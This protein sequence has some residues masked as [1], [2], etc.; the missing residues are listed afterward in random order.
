MAVSAQI[1]QKYLRPSMNKGDTFVILSYDWRDLFRTN[2]DAVREKLA[3]D[4]LDTTKNNFFFISWGVDS[5]VTNLD[6]TLGT[7]HLKAR[8]RRLRPLYDFLLRY[9][10]SG[11]LKKHKL[12]PK[13]I[14][15]YDLGMAYA[16]SR[17]AKRY[18][19]PLILVITNLPDTLL[20]TRKH[21][22]IRQY[23]QHFVE[24]HAAPRVSHVW[25]ISSATHQYARSLGI[26]EEAIHRLVPDSITPYLASIQ[27]ITKGTVREKLG[28]PPGRHIL[29]SVGRL[30]PEKGFDR[31]LDA[32]ANIKHDDLT[33]VIVGDGILR[34]GLEEKAKILGIEKH[35]HF[36]GAV[37]HDELWEYYTD[38][39]MFVLLSRS[40][41]L[42][43]VV[44]EAMYTGLPVIGSRAEGIIESIGK[45]NER[46]F[47]W[48][49]AD[50]YSIFRHHIDSIIG[51]E[52]EVVEKSARA[53]EYVREKL[54]QHQILTE[55]ITF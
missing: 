36:A 50:G 53:K 3:R 15:V 46:G 10:L 22:G 51:S 24:R 26:Q 13:G 45:N 7:V 11:I 12:Q 21:A 49:E 1:C 9:K 5:Y 31:L 35:V 54:E 42:G 37:P 4:R 34:E 28:I 16:A 23:Y 17:A 32:F 27:K 14:I 38:C 43:L 20:K 18:G 40:E 47:L 2:P 29:L 55:V 41:A 44:W 8:F 30:E 52:R 48:D 39:D 25:V 6:S 19:I 33:L